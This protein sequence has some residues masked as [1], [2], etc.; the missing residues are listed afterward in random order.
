MLGYVRDWMQSPVVVIDPDSSASYAMT[1]MRRRQIHSLIVDLSREASG[2]GIL[3]TTGISRKIVAAD[4]N[5][6]E[7]KVRDIMTAPV[8]TGQPDWTL[9]EASQVIQKHKFHH[10][11]IEAN[12]VLVGILSDT[13]IFIAVEEIGWKQ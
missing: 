9:K 6:A 7:V 10:L 11:P 3:T 1:L 5:P 8:I 4:A 2:Y 12:G 13:D